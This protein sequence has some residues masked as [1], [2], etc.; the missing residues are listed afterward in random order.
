[1][2]TPTAERIV[3]VE[4]EGAL[5]WLTL[6]RPAQANSIN[7]HLAAEVIEALSTLG[8]D[9][10]IRVLIIT[11]AGK[12]FCGGADLKSVTADREAGHPN[13]SGDLCDALAA[14][15]IPV[16]AM[17]NGA[18]VGGGCEIALC[19]DLRVMASSAVM[20]L[21]EIRF[22]ALPAAGGTQRM[23]R[24]AGIALA[25][26]YIMTGRTI[27]AN[28]ALRTGLV[29][30]V[31]EPD[32]LRQQTRD[33]AELVA[34]RA[35]YA[36]VAAKSLIVGASETPLAEGIPRESQVIADM[37]TPEEREAEQQRAAAATTTYAKLFPAD[38]PAGGMLLGRR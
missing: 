35:R 19:C 30:R 7:R 18:A 38:R 5:G 29:N 3:T 2:M 36:L 22:G 4:R 27:P 24:A 15:E 6:N 34:S 25:S 14:V 28:E 21:P 20:A 12:L 17:I 32:D 13:P 33:L 1:M 11:G 31:T 16:I 37:A 8:T 10:D 26:E 9:P 23:S